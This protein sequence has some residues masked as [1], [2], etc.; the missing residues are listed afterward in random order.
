[1]EKLEPNGQRA[2]KAITLLWIVLSLEVLMLISGY[3]QYDLLQT[4]ANGGE[5]SAEAAER[6][7]LREFIIG[8]ISFIAFFVYTITFLLWFKRAYSNLHKKTTG[9]SYTAGWAVGS[10]FVP[11]IN[12]YRPYK[13]MKELYC[14]TKKILNDETISTCLL[15][16]WWAFFLIEG[17]INKIIFRYSLKAET[18]EQLISST[19][20]SMIG[21]IISISFA[22]ITIKVIKDYSKMESLLFQADENYLEEPKEELEENKQKNELQEKA[23]D[24][25]KEYSQTTE[26]GENDKFAFLIPIAFIIIG[27]LIVAI[28]NFFR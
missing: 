4:I 3:F 7:D 18:I 12:F 1:M 24:I 23:P 5:I 26:E 10:W 14:E 11:I 25:E 21:N 15:G 27:I 8:V 20:A 22:L 16:W 19:V 28:I 6:N 2:K 9:L 13:I 17:S